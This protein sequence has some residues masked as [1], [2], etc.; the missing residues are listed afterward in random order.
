MIHRATGVARSTVQEYLRTC[1]QHSLTYEQAKG[2]SDS[3]LRER[4]KKKTP[5]RHRTEVRE[6]DYSVINGE[7][8]SRKAA[9]RHHPIHFLG[10]ISPRRRRYVSRQPSLFSHSIHFGV[11]S[12]APKNIGGVALSIG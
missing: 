5:G 7:F 11:V 12:K 6:P 9:L 10:P 1:R 3:E 4:L 8:L 2:L